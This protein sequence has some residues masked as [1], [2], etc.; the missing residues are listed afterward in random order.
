[1]L[2]VLWWG[3]GEVLVGRRGRG[4]I[5]TQHT[6]ADCTQVQPGYCNMAAAA[7]LQQRLHLQLRTLQSATECRAGVGGGCRGPCNTRMFRNP[8]TPTP[9]T[10]LG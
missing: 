1:M 8:P 2:L 7:K 4:Q 5:H 9:T 10:D 6:A 3:G